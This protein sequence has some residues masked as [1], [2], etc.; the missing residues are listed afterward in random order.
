MA[1]AQK[2]YFVFRRNRRVHLNQQGTS[3][4]STTGSRGARI[5]GSNAGY[6]MFQGSVKSTGYPLH[7]PVSPSIP[8]PCVTV[9]QHISTGLYLDIQK[10]DSTTWLPWFLECSDGQDSPF[11]WYMTS[12]HK[13]FSALRRNIGPRRMLGLWAEDSIFL[14]N[15]RIRL[16]VVRLHDAEE[17]CSQLQRENVKRCWLWWLETDGTV[18]LSYPLLS[19]DIGLCYQR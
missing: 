11:F 19:F 17:R 7:S 2:P 12:L 4:Q 15:F 8:L 3:V 16:P 13:D 10:G 9:C 5:S 18:S 1:H 6:T 14:R